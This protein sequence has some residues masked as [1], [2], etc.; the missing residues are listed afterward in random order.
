MDDDTLVDPFRLI[1]PATDLRDQYLELFFS[2]AR[3]F[4][5][6]GEPIL[7]TDPIYLTAVFHSTGPAASYVREHGIFARDFGGDASCPVWWQAPYLILPLSIDQPEEPKM[8][9]AILAEE[10]GCD[11]ATFIFLPLRDDLPG[12]LRDR[13]EHILLRRNGAALK[14][15]A[16]EW[17]LYYE[18]WEDQAGQWS[19]FYRNVVLMWEPDET[20]QPRLFLE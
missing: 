4:R 17:I 18:Q 5:T 8:G 11:S 2:D 10:V 1:A 9:V 6:A 13:I 14:L 3:R 19:E 16:G 20:V 12:E 15:P 7:V